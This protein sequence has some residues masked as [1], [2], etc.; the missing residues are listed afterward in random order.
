MIPLVAASLLLSSG[1]PVADAYRLLVDRGATPGLAWAQVRD[2][3]VIRH[4]EYGYADL[5]NR[6]RVRRE[7]KFEIGSMTKQFTAAIVS[8]LAQEGKLGLDDPAGK[9]LTDLPEEW[10]PLTLRR[11]LSHT[12]GL[13]DYLG[14]MSITE[15]R[16][17]P[18]KEIVDKMGK[19]KLD[20]APGTSWSYSNTG[21][22]VLSMIIEKIDGK[23]LAQSMQDRL[24]KPLGMKDTGSSLPDEVLANR[25]RGYMRAAKGWKNTPTI[26]PSLAFGAGFLVST[27]DDLALWQK[28]LQSGKIPT[29]EMWKPVALNDGRL[30]NYGLG[31][32]IEP[33]DGKTIV[34]HGGNTVGQSANILMM[35]NRREALV[36]LTNASG[37]NP[38]AQSRYVAGL[39]DPKLSMEGRAK[40]DPNPRQTLEFAV[41]LR[42][43]G[44]NVADTSM[45]SPEF[46]GTLSTLR[47][48]SLR[49]ALGS[50]G[51]AM[52]TLTYIDEDRFGED[53]WVRYRLDLGKASG[54]MVFRWSPQ[55]KVVQI[56]QVYAH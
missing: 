29:E 17:F 30:W 28:A 23:P 3:R 4:G 33:I 53:R 45:F 40:A 35:P 34:Y 56:D 22:H 55:G 9:Y 26:N 14:A 27:L 31:W 7:T 39:L 36:V 15:T 12:A 37:L 41:V 50:L 11:L 6:V 18:P 51:K 47:G 10:R 2:G 21:Y 25:A 16:Y 5:E 52:K 54:Y 38:G 24:F 20:F 49:Q 44:R 32:M 46:N 19:S 13:K 1:D 42:K 43:W 8:L 48:V